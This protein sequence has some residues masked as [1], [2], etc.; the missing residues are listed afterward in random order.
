M[1]SMVFKQLRQKPLQK[2][3]DTCLFRPYDFTTTRYDLLRTQIRASDP[4]VFTYLVFG[5]V[6]GKLDADPF[7]FNMSGTRPNWV[8][9]H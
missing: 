3:T 4:V 2:Y 6:Q 9:V 5:W 1:V 7:V 8:L